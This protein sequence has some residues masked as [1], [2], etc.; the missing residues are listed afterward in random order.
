MTD[1]LKKPFADP[2]VELLGVSVHRLAWDD[3]KAG[4]A[5]AA[6]NNRRWI[7]ANH[8]F[9]SVYL[10]HH[11][12]AVRAFYSKAAYAYVDGMPLVFLGR[13]LGL[14]LGR[15][16][17]L[18]P[19]DWLRPLCAEAARRCWR[20]FYLGSKPDVA[21]RGARRLREEFPGLR[22]KTAH[23]YFDTRPDGEE[24]RAV[25][26]A[27]NR[28]RP[29]LLMVGMGMPRQEKWILHNLEK[30]D[31]GAVFNVGALMDYVAGEIPTPPRW[32][33]QIG[34][35][36]LFRLLSQPRHLWRRYLVEPWFV[37][38]LFVSECAQRK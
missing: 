3:L 4:I 1:V 28:C 11:D 22:I 12:P 35:E 5:E 33:G 25:V 37:L 31:A 14:A 8:N 10:Y 34:L 21:E 29:H 7:I 13:L 2:A 30:V 6:E 16:N 23:G 27:I 32:A 26:E 36:W 19:L 15:K 18:T 9:H 20:I 24:N 17:R 38:R